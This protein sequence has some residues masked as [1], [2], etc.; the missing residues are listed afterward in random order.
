MPEIGMPDSRLRGGGVRD[1]LM[2]AKLRSEI[3][4]SMPRRLCGRGFALSKRACMGPGLSCGSG[5]CYAVSGRR[6]WPSACAEGSSPAAKAFSTRPTM[7]SLVVRPD[8]A[9]PDSIASASCS[10]HRIVMVTRGP[11]LRLPPRPRPCL[12]AERLVLSLMPE[13]IAETDSDSA[14]LARYGRV[15]VTANENGPAVPRPPLARSLMLSAYQ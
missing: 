1:S 14:D 3:P 15:A 12:R 5:E 2:A 9:R 4:C 8:L 11:L 7:K 6:S 13:I 10:G